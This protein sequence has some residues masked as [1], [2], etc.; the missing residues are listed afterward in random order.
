MSLYELKQIFEKVN[1]SVKPY[2][3]K[4]ILMEFL[5]ESEDE[6]ILNI[7]ED[8]EKLNFNVTSEKLKDLIKEQS[9]F[10]EFENT[11]T[12]DIVDEIVILLNEYGYDSEGKEYTFVVNKDNLNL[13]FEF[14]ERNNLK[15][16]EIVNDYNGR[17]VELNHLLKNQSDDL[18][19]IVNNIIDLTEYVLNNVGNLKNMGLKLKRSKF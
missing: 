12:S 19:Q 16:I 14:D 9:M 13:I 8:L 3:L 7:Y 1:Y 11:F 6:S 10:E 15:L 4:R 18:D 2:A 5:N 17:I